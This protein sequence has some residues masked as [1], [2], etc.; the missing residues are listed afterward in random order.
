M[1]KKAKAGKG[2]QDN[3]ATFGNRLE[4]EL[5]EQDLGEEAGDEG[6]LDTDPEDEEVEEGDEDGEAGEDLGESE[7]EESEEEAG[8]EEESEEEGESE[9]GEESESSEG[10]EP[11][12]KKK[13]AA[14]S[15]SSEG[16]GHGT[17]RTVP[18]PALLSERKKR[19]DAEARATK[20][21]RELA[22]L[23]GEGTATEN[24]EPAETPSAV[25]NLEAKFDSRHQAQSFKAARRSFKDFDEKAQAVAEAAK[26]DERILDMIEAAED[27]GEA[28]YLYGEEL[29]YQKKYGRTRSE[30]HENLTKE[31]TETLT[32]KIRA[33]VEAEVLGKLRKKRTQPTNISGSRAAGGSDVK[34]YRGSTFGQRLRLR[35]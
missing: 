27:P 13:K 15:E 18:I 1:A 3:G 4:E 10:D 23:R 29:L 25:K 9:E 14:D 33:E 26:V 22:Q 20:A 24:H 2:Q 19:Q 30:Q 28:T 5:Q 34:T 6:D 11:A 35:G 21:E 17:D 8:E 16:E 12:P 31:L 7:E 32:K